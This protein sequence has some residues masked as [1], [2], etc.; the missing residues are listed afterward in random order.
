MTLLTRE[1]E[2]SLKDLCNRFKGSQ[3]KG[4]WDACLNEH[5]TDELST[6]YQT[7][8]SQKKRKSETT[9][10]HM[11][12]EM[13]E[14]NSKRRKT[15]LAAQVNTEDGLA[16]GQEDLDVMQLDKEL[17]VDSSVKPPAPEEDCSSVLP[18]HIKVK[19]KWAKII[20]ACLKHDTTNQGFGHKSVFFFHYFL[21]S[22]CK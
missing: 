14:P 16:V 9:D 18:D 15:D 3:E 20:M 2:L 4:G 22:I 1:C 11:D 7:D 12:G 13:D 19:W 5:Q 6:E 21:F 17:E 8:T 10:L